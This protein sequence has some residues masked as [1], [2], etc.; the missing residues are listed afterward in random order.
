MNTEHASTASDAI[1]RDVQVHLVS[2]PLSVPYRVSQKTHFEFPVLISE[3]WTEDGRYGFG[4]AVISS[5]Y[6]SETIKGGFKYCSEIA[7]QLIGRNLR[8]AESHVIGH[9]AEHSHAVSTILCALGM[10]GEDPMLAIDEDCRIPLLAPCEAKVFEDIPAEVDDLYARGFRTLK[11]KVGFDV[12]ADL[13]RIDALRRAADGRLEFR[14]DANRGFSRADGCNF[15]AHLPD[16]G[17]VVLF[18]QPC[19]THDWDDNA[20]V[21]AVSK[22]PVMLDESIYGLDDIDRA[23]TIV[24]VGFVKLK[25]KKMGSLTRLRD[26][27]IHIRENGMEPVLGDGVASE[28]VCWMESCVARS[29]IRNAGEMN[30]FLKLTSR[31]FQEPLPFEDGHIVLRKGYRPELDRKALAAN[32]AQTVRFSPSFA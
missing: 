7:P 13:D 10:A 24:G 25:L 5:G 14:L 21:A 29:T 4:E 16:D 22:V 12:N 15:G 6:T 11:V 31:L 1:I 26:A 2:L 32:D 28:I 23:G 18:E 27:L 8:D 17:S 9:L 30:G 20:A 19:G 3:Y